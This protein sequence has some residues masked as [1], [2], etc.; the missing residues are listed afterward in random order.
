MGMVPIREYA[1]SHGKAGG[2]VRQMAQRGG[3]RTARKIGRDWLVDADEP[4][5]DR[6]KHVKEAFNPMA[7][8]KDGNG[9]TPFSEDELQGMLKTV[10][11]RQYSRIGTFSEMFSRNWEHMPVQLRKELTPEQLGWTVDLL[12]D[13]YHAGQQHP[14]G[15]NTGDGTCQV[16]NM[17]P[18]IW[19]L[20]PERL[21]ALLT[22]E[23]TGLLLEA[24]TGSYL[25]GL[26]NPER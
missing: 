23:Q 25:L 24:V 17:I 5:P 20:I 7:W 12:A 3:L 19:N 18:E 4:Y 10:Q 15:G 9:E 16:R 26:R 21:T 13:S 2:T 1:K 22:H 14:Q 8:E 6:R 11:A